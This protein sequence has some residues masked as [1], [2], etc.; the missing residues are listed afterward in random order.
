MTIEPRKDTP[1]ARYV[2]RKSRE[3]RSGVTSSAQRRQPITATPGI[4]SAAAAA[5][6]AIS[7]VPCRIDGYRIVTAATNV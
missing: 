6:D 1:A 4:L 5:R 7:R 2:S 3:V